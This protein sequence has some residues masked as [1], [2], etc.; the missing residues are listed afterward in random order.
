MKRLWKMLGLLTIGG[1]KGYCE[2]QTSV[3]W[4]TDGGS[5]SQ[6]PDHAGSWLAAGAGA[7]DLRCPS[8]M[9][10]ILF[11]SLSLAAK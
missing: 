10:M 1:A 7:M 8:K 9:A 6:P 4:K 3:V 5:S 2:Q 11:V